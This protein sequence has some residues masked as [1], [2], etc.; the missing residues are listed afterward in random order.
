MRGS[1]GARSC[2]L[3]EG[4]RKTR[5]QF[6]EPMFE[7]EGISANER[8]TDAEQHD[9]GH[10]TPGSDSLQWA[11]SQCSASV[12]V[13][14]RAESGRRGC[15][16]RSSGPGRPCVFACH[17]I[18]LARIH[19]PYAL[20]SNPRKSNP[21]PRAARPAR[22]WRCATLVAPRAPR[23]PCRRERRG[24]CG[25]GRARS[26]TPSLPWIPVADGRSPNLGRVPVD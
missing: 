24:W 3:S 15:S 21:E 7:T 25:R 16:P 26:W 23:E 22:R 12:R 13:A 6:D 11:C 9:R 5:P 18:L 17:G 20:Q 2:G 14:A 4:A 10:I 8:N 1:R 19:G